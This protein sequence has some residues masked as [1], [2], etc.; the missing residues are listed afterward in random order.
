VTRVGII[1]CAAYSEKCAGY[2]CFPA[3]RERTGPFAEYEDELLL[4]GFDTCGGCSRNEMGKIVDRAVRLRDRGAEV[5]H[6]GNCLVSACPWA[7]VFRD[8][9]IKE[10]GVPVALRT[11][12]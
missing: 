11:H 5:I 6:L 12:P 9:I 8:A 7:Q 1:R 4:I 3:L 10:T 2:K